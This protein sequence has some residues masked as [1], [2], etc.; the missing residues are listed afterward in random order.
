MKR[1]III[2]TFISFL[3]FT[4]ALFGLSENTICPSHV[5]G[6]AICL[7]ASKCEAF[8]TER[9]K[10]GICSFNG[11]IPIVCCP[12]Q[13]QSG[14]NNGNSKLRRI[15]DIKCEEFNE[16][17]TIARVNPA[18]QLI[19]SSLTGKPKPPKIEFFVGGTKANLNEFPHMSAI[20]LKRSN[21]QTDWMCG[22]SLISEKFVLSA[23][24]CALFGRRR[25]DIIR[26]GDQDLLATDHGISPQEFTIKNIIVHPKYKN[27]LKYHDLG[28]FELN[29]SAQISKDVSPACLYQL[30]NDPQETLAMG[31][32]QTS[33]SGQQSN[34]LIKGFLTIVNNDQCNLAYEDDILELPQGI[35][36]SQICAWDP[37]GSLDTCQ[38]DSGGPLQITKNTKTFKKYY[39]IVG[40]TS[41]GKFCAAGVPG[42]YVRVFSYLDWIENVVWK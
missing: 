21:N 29:S 26:V 17:R 4:T 33:F 37:N 10:L 22:G 3:N 20:G 18:A 38:G 34:T 24:H 16:Q 6:D 23:A 14:E 15:S 5:S 40:I 9:N 41:F 12:K 28:L 8:K 31:Y 39:E 1:F 7:E 19:Q 30:S 36:S 42:V 11:R 2:I 35:T 13:Q 32:G 25:P 27:N